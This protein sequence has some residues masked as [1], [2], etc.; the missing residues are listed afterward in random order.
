MS[1]GAN[2]QPPAPPP[3]VG[4]RQSPGG[5]SVGLLPPRQPYRGSIESTKQAATSLHRDGQSLPSAERWGGPPAADLRAGP[6]ARAAV[7]IQEGGQCPQQAPAASPA[8]VPGAFPDPSSPGGCPGHSSRSVPQRNCFWQRMR[9]TGPVHALLQRHWERSEAPAMAWVY[10]E[11]RQDGDVCQS[12]RAQSP[13]HLVWVEQEVVFMI[14]FLGGR[15]LRKSRIKVRTVNLEGIWEQKR[16]VRGRD[17][18]GEGA[19]W[20]GAPLPAAPGTSSS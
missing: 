5:G 19:A 11:A 7:C 18:G 2:A 14:V 9:E 15:A 17:P 12:Q 13:I 4:P 3:G 1:P 6:R 8:R 10:F 20:P 16:D